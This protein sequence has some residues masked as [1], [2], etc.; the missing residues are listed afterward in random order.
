MTKECTKWLH[1]HYDKFRYFAEVPFDVIMEEPQ[2]CD[3]FCR[4][5]KRSI[6]SGVDETIE[7]YGTQPPERFGLPDILI[8]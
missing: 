1:D 2:A 3:E 6:E 4:V 5:L 8:D 7:R